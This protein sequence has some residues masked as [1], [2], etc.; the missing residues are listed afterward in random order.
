MTIEAKQASKGDK[1][2]LVVMTLSG[3]VNN[4]SVTV[5]VRLMKVGG[6][7]LHDDLIVP[8]PVKLHQPREAHVASLPPFAE[9]LG[10]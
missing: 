2:Y 7:E 8:V 1:V 9:A 3:L 10:L 6:I 4:I 5:I